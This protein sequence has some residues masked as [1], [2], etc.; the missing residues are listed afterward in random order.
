MRKG[1]D[2]MNIVQF[3]VFGR[4]SKPTGSIAQAKFAKHGCH[5]TLVLIL[6]MPELPSM[7]ITVASGPM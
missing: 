3:E 4:R 1:V 7:L 2:N 6:T 5:S